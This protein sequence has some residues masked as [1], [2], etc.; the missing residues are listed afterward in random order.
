M[1]D[2]T[3]SEIRDDIIVYLDDPHTKG[4]IEQEI[5]APVDIIDLILLQLARDGRIA[6][7]PGS[8]ANKWQTKTKVKQRLAAMD[9][10]GE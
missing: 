4:E 9:G 1:T 6:I 3:V 8:N 7:S 5:D 2:R 10:D